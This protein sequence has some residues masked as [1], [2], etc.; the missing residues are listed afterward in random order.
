MN[1]KLEF[2]L[3][4]WGSAATERPAREKYRQFTTQYEATLALLES[5]GEPTSC[6]VFNG[7]ANYYRGSEPIATMRVRFVP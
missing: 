2:T 4:L 6:E 3:A 1:P 7:E 5:C